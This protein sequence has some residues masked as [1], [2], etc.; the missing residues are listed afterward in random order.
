[1]QLEPVV[2]SLIGQGCR[3][4]L[5][6]SPHPVLGM[7]LQETAE[8]ATDDPA[9]VAVLGTLRREEGGAERFGQSLAEAHAAGVEVDWGRFFE[10]SGGE[11]VKLPVYPFQRRRYWL[12]PPEAWG[13]AGAA[14][15]ND[16]D[17]PLL[18]AEIDFPAGEGLQLTGRISL[19]TQRWLKDH[20]VLGQTLLPSTVYVE[21]ALAAASATGAG[22]I[23]ELALETPLLIPDSGGVQLRV[24]V[25]SPAEGGQRAIA[26][27]SRLEGEAG[28]DWVR[29]ASGL[30]SAEPVTAGVTDDDEVP[31]SWPV[32]EAEQL[33]V[34][35]AY[36]RLEESGFELG[37][38]FR[39]LRA[40][41]R[42]G[43]EVLVEAEL[44]EERAGD[45]TG[46]ELHPALLES[47]TRAGIGFAAAA[48]DAP[49]LPVAWRAVRLAKPKATALRFRIA[50]GGTASS[51]RVRPAG[52]G[53]SLGWVR[54]GAAGGASPA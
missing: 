28:E 34:E 9:S 51:H 21:L 26:I 22:G 19:S 43:E 23:E 31:M 45:A 3:A 53:G 6:V 41:W 1:M 5:E 46:F 33:D 24:S 27:H 52:R 20:T 50:S 15:L 30:L 54:A 37:P 49:V 47:A 8:A 32:E 25:E 7:G 42:S 16:P 39:C 4:L 13:D 40:A 38:A 2:R 11:R 12:E 14:G 44:A 17:H 36:E 29:H 35:L 10:G 18:A 48:D